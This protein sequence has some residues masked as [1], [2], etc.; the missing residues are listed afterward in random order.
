MRLLAIAAV[1][2]AC[3]AIWATA[4]GS[5]F[6]VTW[7]TWISAALL[8]WFLEGLTGW[9][10]AVPAIYRRPPATAPPAQT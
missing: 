1:V 7:D 3:F 6:G 10:L 9:T 5:C 4:F 2:L 8:A